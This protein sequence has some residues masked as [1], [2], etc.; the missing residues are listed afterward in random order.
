M[1]NKDLLV[2]VDSGHGGVDGGASNGNILEKDLTLKASK[3]I[4]E[5]LKQLGIQAVMTREEDIDLPKNE[6]INKINQI[7]NKDPR[8]IVLS[9]HINAGG[10]E[11][12]EVVYGLRNDSTLADMIL[13]NIGNNGQLKRKA[14]QRR[15]P[16]N[17]N[18]DYYYII[19]ETNP[20]Q[21]VLIEY[22][23]IDNKNDL[24]KL[25]NNLL[26]Y[27]EG[28]V[29]AVADY[30]NTVYTKPNQDVSEGADV[31]KVEKGDTL[32][33][34]ARRFGLSVDELKS[35]N[36]MT[37]NML[38]IGQILKLTKEENKSSD[39]DVYVV[40]KGDSLWS[41]SRKLGINLNELIN[42][43]NLTSTT[44]SIGQKLKIPSLN[45]ESYIVQKGDTLYSI[46]KRFNTTIDNIINKNNLSTTV[47]SI[48]QQLNI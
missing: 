8:V 46:A 21:S 41:I 7:S 26:D 45:K 9:N 27:A 1:N 43:N 30:T 5:R 23:F 44:I 14:Y 20:R 42:S 10:G 37:S 39:D 33:S 32:W 38:S 29:K 40:Q 17:P 25:Q 28:V 13:E 22:G 3:Y 4:Y 6:R 15:L 47:L 35:I 48:G 18:K 19:R 34:I 16:E 2:V 11:G 36:N 12:A 24:T 31:Y